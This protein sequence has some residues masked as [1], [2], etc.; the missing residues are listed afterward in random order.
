MHTET[1]QTPAPP[2]APTLRALVPRVDIYEREGDLVLIADMPG[3][4][5]PDV[6]IQLEKNSL[7]DRKSVV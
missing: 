5:E 6:D 2:K 1:V 7:T 3:V 4:K